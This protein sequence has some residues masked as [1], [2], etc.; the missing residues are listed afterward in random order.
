[1][2]DLLLPQQASQTQII[3]HILY[4]LD[5]VLDAI[6]ALPQNI[7]LEVEDLEAGMHVFDELADLQWTP[8]VT[9]SH[10]VAG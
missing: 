3:H 10:A 1:M 7:V 5:P 4:I 8:I 9:Q 2:I 6:T